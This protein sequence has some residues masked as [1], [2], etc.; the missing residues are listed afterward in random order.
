[1]SI[2]KSGVSPAEDLGK[3]V[4]ASQT[5]TQSPLETIP[6]EIRLRI[7]GYVIVNRWDD[8]RVSSLSMIVSC[9]ILAPVG[10]LTVHQTP[11]D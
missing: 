6:V 5:S 11:Y 7:Y 8:I 10:S 2:P 4:E 9:A 3:G 1:M